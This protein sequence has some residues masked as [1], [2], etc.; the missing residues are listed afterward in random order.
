MRIAVTSQNWQTV[1]AHPGKSTRFLIFETDASGCA[2]AAGRL[3][4][5][6][7]HL[8]RCSSNDDHPLFQMDVILSASAGPEMI[9]HL[10]QRGVHLLATPEKNPQVA[11]DNFI[12]NL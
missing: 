6:H 9:H 4:V 1:T 5:D 2:R 8:L 7:A 11:V 12:S 3:E 10:L